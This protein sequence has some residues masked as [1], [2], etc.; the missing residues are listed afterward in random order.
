MNLIKKT[1]NK[2]LPDLC[3]LGLGETVSQV[4]LGTHIGHIDSPLSTALPHIVVGNAVGLLLQLGGGIGAVV[5]HR[6]VVCQYTTR[7]SN[8]NSHVGQLQPQTLYQLHS[9]LHG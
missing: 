2:S 6:H 4:L 5:D 3:R 9:S 8:I 7:Q 1:R